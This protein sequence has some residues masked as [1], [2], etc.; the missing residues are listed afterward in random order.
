MYRIMIVDDEPIIRKGLTHFIDWSSL[1]CAIVNESS[2][3]LEARDLLDSVNPHIVITDIQMPEFDGLHLAQYIYQ[4]Y[5]DIKVIILT[6]HADFAY[7]QSAIA[8]DVVDFILKPTVTENI[9][10]AV[11]KAKRQIQ[12]QQE[13]AELVHVLED[14]VKENLMEMREN[15]LRDLIHGMIMDPHIIQQQFQRLDIQMNHYFV[16]GYELISYTND[17]MADP[18]LDLSPFLPTLKQFLPQS[19]PGCL[20]YDLLLNPTTMCTVLVLEGGSPE[21]CLQKTVQQ[22]KELLHTI[23]HLTPYR[24]SIGISDMHHNAM[25]MAEAYEEALIALSNEFGNQE[26]LSVYSRQQFADSESNDQ[27]LTEKSMNQL[28]TSM[29]KG[30]TEQTATLIHELVRQ[31]RSSKQPVEEIQN[32]CILV[33]SLSSNLLANYNMTLAGLIPGG[34]QL[35]KRIVQTRSLL[36]LANL[37]EE[38]T[39]ATARY[40]KSADKQNNYIVAKAMEFI[41]ENYD[42]SIQLQQIAEY[43]PVNSSY[44]SRLFRKETGETLTDAVNKQRIE[45]AKELL[46]STELKTYEIA[47]KVGIEDPAYFS[48]IFKKYTGTSPKKFKIQG[49]L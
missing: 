5:P 36:Y 37:I 32:I 1:D 44:L 20:H 34:E 25:D 12:V 42:K 45:K 18:V 16:I 19:F 15:L 10:D 33:C 43:I 11:N 21:E 49:E 40:L 28:I 4:Y 46:Q 14:K 39:A 31:F 47:A 30:N 23:H 41:R 3:G 2:D 17:G 35:Y 48:Q 29:Q 7:A 38:V 26:G 13:Q 8:Y 9:I 27:S 24:I 22:C 6:G